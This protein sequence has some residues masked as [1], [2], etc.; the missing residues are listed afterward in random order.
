[1]TSPSRARDS[2]ARS[3]SSASRK[4][5][6]NASASSGVATDGVLDL[7]V[8]KDE[9]PKPSASRSHAKA[10]T[11]GAYGSMSA[12]AS[13][14]RERGEITEYDR[15]LRNAAE[16]QMEAFAS[17][18]QQNM[19]S[20]PYYS[21]ML[22]AMAMSM[23]DPTLFPV[24]PM[25]PGAAPPSTPPLAKVDGRSLKGRGRGRQRNR[26]R[27][28]A[29]SASASS[30]SER[31]TPTLPFPPLENGELSSPA[32]SPQTSLSRGS[33][34]GRSRG[35]SGKSASSRGRGRSRNVESKSLAELAMEVRVARDERAFNCSSP[36]LFL[37]QFHRRQTEE[38]DTQRSSQAHSNGLLFDPMMA[39]AFSASGVNVSLL[40]AFNL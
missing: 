2:P 20:D 16:K 32:P 12:G 26:G 6:K 18:M 13:V 35:G 24:A 11:S 17:A 19:M 4:A 25:M 40:S 38:P 3:E 15:Q 39:A 34:R 29:A 27:G 10:S 5:R 7:S 21:Q 31:S 30:V 36:S 37:L 8:K 1:M 22:S 23:F 14:E 9:T 33:G 28:A